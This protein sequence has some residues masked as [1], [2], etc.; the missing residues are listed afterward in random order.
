MAIKRNFY[1]KFGE[2]KIDIVNFLHTENHPFKDH[3]LSQPH[4]ELT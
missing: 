2:Q 4:I 1:K 3:V